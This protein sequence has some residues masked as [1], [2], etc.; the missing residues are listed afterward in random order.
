M[1]ALLV[2]ASLSAE[3]Q[4]AEVQF[5]G[6]YRARFRMIDTL[7][8]NRDIQA[9]EGLATLAQ[10]RLW[11]K[12]RF[13]LSEHVGLFVEIRA[14]DGVP[15]GTQVG[16][17]DALGA[18]NALEYGLTAPT[19]ATDEATTLLDITLWRAYGQVHTPLGLFTFGRVPLHW[20]TGI[21]LNDGY[22]VNPLYADYGDTTD[23]VMFERLVEDSVYIRAS[24]DLPAE[25]LVGEND[26]TTAFGVAG[27]YKSEDI[28]VGVLA[29]L[30]HRAPR[31]DEGLRSLNV[32]TVDVA[33]DAVVG[34]LDLALEA[35]GQFGGGDVE[36]RANDAVIED[37]GIT[38]VGGVL[39]A[40]LDLAPWR[41][42]LDGGFATGD[43]QANV[44]LRTFAFDRD[45]SVGMFLFEQPM[46]TLATAAGERDYEAVVTGT[47]LSNA[48]YVKPRVKLDPIEGVT[49]DASWLGARVAKA[50]EFAGVKQSRGYGNEFQL[51]A[52]YHGVPH[53]TVDGRFGL[54]LP[55]SA[56]SVAPDGQTPTDYSQPAFGFQLT[57]RIAF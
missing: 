33:G 6:F 2:L 8:L 46:P 53:F 50:Q 30:D 34:K 31:A 39:Q 41:V 10:H 51:G 3:S 9:S 21:W 36:D 54:F 44:D 37:A 20:G 38:A 4:A 55:G 42:E 19:S 45:Y 52:S 27:A 48:L 22:S 11:L 1:H 26:D 28:N 5:E 56:Y 14:L 49:V 16:D 12:P 29:Q 57:G 35:I 40:G 24:V 7:S 43:G 18:P 25:R 15:W 17:Y 47:A 13:L 32:F 23:R